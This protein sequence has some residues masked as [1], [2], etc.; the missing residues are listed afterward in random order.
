MLPILG[1][2]SQTKCPTENESIETSLLK[3]KKVYTHI[4]LFVLQA[5]SFL[6]RENIRRHWTVLYNQL[7]TAT[8][9]RTRA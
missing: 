4:Y 1:N 9:N 5:L 7:P 3:K 8:E 2:K 6:R